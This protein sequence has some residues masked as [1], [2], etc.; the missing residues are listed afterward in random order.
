M[1]PETKENQPMSLLLQ[2]FLY[3]AETSRDQLPLNYP[4]LCQPETCMPQP[5]TKLLSSLASLKPQRLTSPL[6]G[7]DPPF[8]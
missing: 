7:S 3:P 2:V 8:S 5:P 6:P 4:S 1:E